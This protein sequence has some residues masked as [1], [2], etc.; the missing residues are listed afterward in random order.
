[1]FESNKTLRKQRNA[2]ERKNKIAKHGIIFKD[3]I[4]IRI[5]QK[6]VPNCMSM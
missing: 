2:M 5:V 4:P 6:N 1:M 3:A